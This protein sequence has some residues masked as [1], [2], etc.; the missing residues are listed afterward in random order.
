MPDI[1]IKPDLEVVVFG[2]TQL[3]EIVEDA[4][5]AAQAAIVSINEKLDLAQ[6]AAN[7]AAE[8]ADRADAGAEVV[9]V[10][11]GVIA[12]R[13]FAVL[14]KA[15][16]EA[17]RDEAQAAASDTDGDRAAV[18]AS[19]AQVSLDRTVV[20]GL[21]GQAQ[22]VAFGSYIDASG[23]VVLGGASTLAGG[24]D[25]VFLNGAGP[26]IGVKGFFA[27]AQAGKDSNCYAAP[28]IGYW[29]GTRS[30]SDF[31]TFY[32]THAGQDVNAVG[33]EAPG[34]GAAA[35]GQITFAGAP[36][37]GET[38][39]VGGVLFTARSSPSG[40]YEFAAGASA[41]AAAAALFSAILAATD[42]SLRLAYYRLNATGGSVIHLRST[43]QGTYGNG[44]ALSASGANVAVSG[45][46]LSGGAMAVNNG[47]PLSTPGDTFVGFYAGADSKRPPAG[48]RGQVTLSFSGQ[49]E[50]GASIAL[51]LNLTL[52]NTA[53]F[54]SA[55]ATA[56]EIA[57]GGSL[58][59]SLVNATAVLNGSANATIGG[60]TYWA[61]HGGQLFIET[62]AVN[63]SSF[64][65][66][67]F[68]TAVITAPFNMAF[69]AFAAFG[70][71]NVAVG[72]NTGVGMVGSGNVMLGG[73]GSHVVGTTNFIVGGGGVQG[74]GNFV[75]GGGFA[76]AEGDDNIAIGRSIQSGLTGPWQA[77]VAITL[78]GVITFAEPHGW[79]QGENF[80]CQYRDRTGGASRL[81]IVPDAQVP[82]GTPGAAV[83]IS[84]VVGG[85]NVM[86]INAVQARI[87]Q[88]AG[89]TTG[90]RDDGYQALGTVGNIDVA[91]FIRQVEQSITIGANALAASRRATIGSRRQTEGTLIDTV[92]LQ[93]GRGEFRLP[94]LIPGV[95]GTGN[96]LFATASG[97][98]ADGETVT[99]NGTVFT[100]KAAAAFATPNSSMARWFRIGA[101]MYES[102]NNLLLCLRHSD[103]Q[104]AAARNAAAPGRFWLSAQTGGGWR[105]SFQSYE[106]GG[107]AYS[108]AT[109]KSGATVTGPTVG[110]FGNLPSSSSL[111]PP[112]DGGIVQLS[113]SP[114]NNN[115][116]GLARYRLSTNS[117]LAL[118]S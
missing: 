97:N 110:T 114:A 112:R 103:D 82:G 26:A 92:G 42:A 60:S 5:L 104:T 48:R 50:E 8:D 14:A 2:E 117:W 1:I 71:H 13:D 51:G 63:N 70:A 86:V 29:C 7:S 34:L 102:L 62:D 16:S 20:S 59:E 115:Q 25:S 28:M 30:I 32:G 91:R 67:P 35:T 111:Y 33:V 85:L 69:G 43:S 37:D 93:L 108:L 49:P 73:G 12:A 68:A 44:F 41:G 99:L 80:T 23:N 17:A 27:G 22:A 96:I 76:Y 89:P 39:T 83:T 31:A 46:F 66:R 4:D 19:A 9:Q 75:W 113:A 118:G 107:T 78:D 94:V 10:A 109:S 105:L 18:S 36:A 38:V 54:R 65:V 6:A 61:G 45:A 11:G 24:E 77:I 53:V 21:V 55:P 56:L 90:L 106:F 100:A 79:T 81:Q 98:F 47:N 57:R 116:P 88:S 87:I 101:D 40:A 84:T 52:A 15:G 64:E 74:N 95:P 3:R 58:I 72:F